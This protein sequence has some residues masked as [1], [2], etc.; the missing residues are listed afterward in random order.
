MQLRPGDLYV[1][2][3]NVKLQHAL[4]QVAP[5]YVEDMHDR[6]VDDHNQALN[7]GDLV[8]FDT[9]P[10]DEAS[11]DVDENGEPSNTVPSAGAAGAGDEAAAGADREVGGAG[12]AAGFKGLRAG[13]RILFQI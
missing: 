13:R 3:S 10:D 4:E 1:H 2:V 5:G 9:R 12:V 7:K 11:G 6:M 8:P